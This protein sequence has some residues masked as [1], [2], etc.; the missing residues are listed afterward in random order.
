MSLRRLKS[1]WEELGRVDPLWAVLVRPE[2]RRGGWTLDEF[3]TTAVEH[4]DRVLELLST[5]DLSLGD[6]VLDFGCGVGRLSNTLAEHATEV[7]GID[8]AQSMIDEANRI[9]R[10]HERL[11]FV[12]Y[13]G[14]KLPFADGYF[15]SVVSLISIQHSPP[16]IQ[17][18]CL[19]EL[20]R[21][22]RPGG[23][24][25]L[26]IP[27]HQHRPVPLGAE[28]MRARIEPLSVPSVIGSGR[29]ATVLAKITNMSGHTWPVESRVRLGNHWYRDGQAVT[30]DDGRSELRREV[31]PGDAVEV[32]LSV[33]AP[34]STGEVELE[35][36]LLQESVVWW[37][38]VG[39]ETTRCHIAVIDATN[40]QIAAN[41]AAQVGNVAE[42]EMYGMDEN[43]VRMLFVHTGCTVIDSVADT[44]AGD[45]WQSRTYVIRAG[46]AR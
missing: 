34:E 43:L 26:Q 13:D 30:W 29:R 9:N 4:V 24:L 8:I 3:L 27:T 46:W 33:T 10:H 37:T 5:R 1:T 22:V 19:V 41:P 28:A 20:R 11:V 12:H 25:V 38:D 35:L 15:D 17:L 44:L 39:S 18:A 14:T 23:V 7:V 32:S 40:E 2:R 42:M 31:A 36:D 16:S 45:D 21:V 6:R